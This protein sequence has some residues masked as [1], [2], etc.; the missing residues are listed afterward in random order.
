M[1]FQPAGLRFS[2]AN[3]ARLK[4]SFREA[5]DDLNGD[6]QIDGNDATVVPLL[7]IWQRESSTSPWTRL[8]SVVSP[9]THEV[10]ASVE[11]F[12]GYIIAW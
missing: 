8:P 6:G 3:P 1:E 12:T 5:D 9:A 11:G 4:L 7:S 2:P 10:E